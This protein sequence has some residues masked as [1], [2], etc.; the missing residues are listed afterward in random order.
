MKLYFVA[1]FVLSVFSGVF[2]II[3]M[4]YFVAH[5]V[6][7]F[8]DP[9]NVFGGAMVLFGLWIGPAGWQFHRTQESARK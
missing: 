9:L 7:I 6:S 8:A 4:Q 2:L 5:D 1:I 3:R